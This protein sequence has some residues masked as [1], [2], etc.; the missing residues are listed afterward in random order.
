MGPDTDL[1]TQGG[2]GTQALPSDTW[3]QT[4]N[5]HADQVYHKFDQSSALCLDCKGVSG[6][7]GGVGGCGEGRGGVERE[8]LMHPT[9]S[10]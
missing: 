1:R 7:V 4:L 6:S 9:G 8:G 3:K 5:C 2:R 10:L